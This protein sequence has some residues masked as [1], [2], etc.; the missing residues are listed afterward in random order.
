MDEFFK[1]VSSIKVSRCIPQCTLARSS[2]QDEYAFMVSLLPSCRR[3]AYPSWF[4]Q[5]CIHWQSITFMNA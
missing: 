4:L 3:Q 2:Q 5:I 1:E